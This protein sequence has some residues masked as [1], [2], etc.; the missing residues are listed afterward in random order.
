MALALDFNPAA[1]DRSADIAEFKPAHHHVEPHLAEGGSKAADTYYSQSPSHRAQEVEAI[2]M[3]MMNREEEVLWQVLDRARLALHGRVVKNQFLFGVFNG[4][5]CQTAFMRY[6]INL[7]VIHTALEDAQKIILDGA[8]RGMPAYMYLAG[9]V[10]PQLFRSRGIAED[11]K[12]WIYIAS[13]AVEEGKEFVVPKPYEGV[14]AYADY[15]KGLVD[16]N[17]ELLVGHLYAWLGTFMSGG[18][19]SKKNVSQKFEIFKEDGMPPGSG[20]E[21]FSIKNGNGTEMSDE[22]IASRS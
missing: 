3:A 11:L 22:E 8:G 16:T 20:V 18:V 6:L 1:A 10:T 2:R 15:L 7:Q 13:K 9:V 19:T 12:P 14:V 17:P 5:F 4:G 21:L